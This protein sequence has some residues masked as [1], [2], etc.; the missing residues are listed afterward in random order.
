[1]DTELPQLD[2]PNLLAQ[3]NGNQLLAAGFI[4]QMS[5]DLIMSDQA[6]LHHPG[7]TQVYFNQVCGY[8]VQEA[9]RRAIL[10]VDAAAEVYNGVMSRHYGAL[11]A[12]LLDTM[13]PA[14]RS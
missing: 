4:V 12:L 3:A 14:Y 5:L 9:S 7:T 11:G 13:F 2:I 6:Q 8:V 1:M 10:P